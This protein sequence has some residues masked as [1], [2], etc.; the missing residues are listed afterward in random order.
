M[1]VTLSH[2][3]GVGVICAA[4]A[5]SIRVVPLLL[6]AVNVPVV[7]PFPIVVERL[8]WVVPALPPDVGVTFRKGPGGVENGIEKVL[9]VRPRDCEV[10]LTLKGPLIGKL[11]EF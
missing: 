11:A 8:N 7:G 5:L 9:D 2:G 6:A 3:C 1:G 4:V 10:T